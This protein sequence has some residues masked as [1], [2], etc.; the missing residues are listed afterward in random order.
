MNHKVIIS[1]RYPDLLREAETDGVQ[2]L[3]DVSTG[4]FLV[5]SALLQADTRGH[6]QKD[7]GKDSSLTSV[8]HFTVLPGGPTFPY[9]VP[10]LCSKRLPKN[11]TQCSKYEGLVVLFN[12]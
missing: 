2:K 9:G 6:F 7:R 1:Q 5:M 8:P 10:T 11:K 4:G 3:R 12:N